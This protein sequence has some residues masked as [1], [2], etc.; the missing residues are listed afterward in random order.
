MLSS[1]LV[2]SFYY[3]NFI[4]A[5]SAPYTNLNAYRAGVIDSNGNIL[6]PESSIDSFEYL[7]IKLKK[8][9]EQLPAGTTKAKLN[10]YAAA[11]QLFS[12]EAS[13]FGM[14]KD[15]V[16]LIIEGFLAANS[17]GE[18]SYIELKE[19][20]TSGNLG[21]PSSSPAQNTG[22]VSGFDAPMGQPMT[23]RLASLL[24]VNKQACEIYDVCPEDFDELSNPN[25]KSWDEVPDSETKRYMQR[26]QRR[27]GGPIILIR[28]SGTNRMHKL[29]L[30]PR[31]LSKII[32]ENAGVVNAY[33]DANDREPSVAVL[34]DKEEKA[35]AKEQKKG[36][37]RPAV[38][39]GTTHEQRFRENMAELIK[40]HTEAK[41]G[42][43]P[44]H[45]AEYEARMLFH[46]KAYHELKDTPHIHEY[47]DTVHQGIIS[48]VSATERSGKG[49]DVH[50]P[51]I[52]DNKLKVEPVEVKTRGAS[53]KRVM[54][55]SLMQ[56]LLDTAPDIMSAWAKAIPGTQRF[57]FPKGDPEAAEERFKQAKE[58][59]EKS[60]DPV[61]VKGREEQI[62]KLKQKAS[63]RTL[64][65]NSDT[66]R[67]HFINTQEGAPEVIMGQQWG[68]GPKTMGK[69]IGRHQ[70]G[71]RVNYY[72]PPEQSEVFSI[73]KDVQDTMLAHVNP[74]QHDYLKNLS[75]VH[76]G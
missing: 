7:I 8:I 30:K 21:G 36:Y 65:K 23:R 31:N 15:T 4:A 61:I 24:G 29:N 22:A 3:S 32:S 47:M 66:G 72:K 69:E 71:Y 19:D 53:S 1:N 68:Q 49:G 56:H 17:N 44:G 28:D 38:S 57:L 73:N 34:T 18:L 59:I 43:K 55:A 26:S 51:S 67:F 14:D 40:L 45:A 46:A 6:K 48:P 35:K 42:G 2:S 5:I 76:I 10:Q 70:V 52:E 37:V 16:E 11:F 27:S 20:V 25:L 50:I 41:T 63:G 60:Q 74:E 9:F 58:A 39:P 12:E 33:N 75:D 13:S 54:P 62:V 64:I